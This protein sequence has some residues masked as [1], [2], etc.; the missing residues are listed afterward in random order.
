MSDEGFV[1]QVQVLQV[2][3]SQL[4]PVFDVCGMVVEQIVDVFQ[5]LV[6]VAVGVRFVLIIF[7][8]GCTHGFGYR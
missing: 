3:V 4:G 7:R 2:Q 6:V 5:F 1:G 8:G